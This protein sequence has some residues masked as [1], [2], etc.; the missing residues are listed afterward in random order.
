MTEM[1]RK[2]TTTPRR[3]IP[4]LYL[5]LAY[6]LA[7]LFWIP[8]ALT[9]RD[10]QASPLLLLVTLAGVF[11]PG[12]AG[13][14]LT[15]AREGEEARRDFWQRAF[16]VRRIRPRWYLL[17]VVLWPA[18]HLVAVALSRLRGAP[19]PAPPLLRELAAQP[20]TIPVVLV[21]YLIQAGLEELGWR[22]YMLERIQPAWGRLGGSLVV[23][24]FHAFWHLPMFWVVGTNQIKMGF[25][26]DFLL[27]VAAAIS[28]SVYATW[29]YN[30]NGRSTLA[31]TLLHCTGNLCVDLC[32]DGPGTVGH[33]VYTLVMVLGAVAIGALWASRARACK[34]AQV[35]RA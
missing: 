7:W 31:A 4:W 20:L 6:S 16:D 8:V 23:G 14:I 32:T 13:I 24:L 2:Y 27:F 29:C 11:G 34:C 30:D 28:M 22:G 5:A 19:M 9:G 18:L 26:L 1:G 21:L 10:Y 3:R 15:Y 12:L 35:V 17:I 33:R 25:G